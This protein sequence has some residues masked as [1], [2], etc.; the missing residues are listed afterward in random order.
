MQDGSQLSLH[1]AMLGFGDTFLPAM[2]P[3]ASSIQALGTGLGFRDL[4]GMLGT[5]LGCW[6]QCGS[7]ERKAPD[8]SPPC[9]VMGPIL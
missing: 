4:A 6:G 7:W 3:A 8:I 9:G 1:L 5:F 2:P